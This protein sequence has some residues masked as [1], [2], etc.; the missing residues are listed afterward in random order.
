LKD[1]I[2]HQKKVLFI[3]RA[4]APENSSTVHRPLK[5]TKF[6]P[7]YGWTP[8]VVT[9]KKHE[10]QTDNSLLKDI[11]REAVISEVFSPEPRNVKAI[12]AE[13]VGKGGFCKLVQYFL[14][15]ILKIYSIIY[16][17]IV[18]IDWYDGWIPFGFFKARQ[19]LKKEDI[20]VIFTDMEPP[21]T[22]IIGLLS[23]KISGMPMVIDYHDPWTTSV[24]ARQ[25][26]GLRKRIA[27]YLEHKILNCADTVIAGKSSIVSELA[28]K[29][30]DID[31]R[32]LVTITSGYDSDDYRDLKK[33]ETS[34]FVITY[35]G[36][37]S[38]KL[39]YSPESFLYALASLIKEGKIPKYDVVSQFVGIVSP[40]Y[41]NRFA[42]LVKDLDLAEVVVCTGGV[43]RR[44]CAEFQLNADVL[45]YIIE[46]L[47]GYN[48]S[49]QYS[50]VLPSKLYEYLFTGN[51]ILG[52]VPPGFEA[53]LIER[54]G[55]GII[56]KPNNIESIKNALLA[57]YKKYK[58]GS[59]KMHTNRE[60]IR[61]FDRKVLT[62]ELAHVFDKIMV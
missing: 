39:Y 43:N 24:N 62:G 27:E 4:F 2:N 7:N 12:L 8:Y 61:K 19:I 57:L 38:E 48:V 3:S 18:L 42:R 6:L 26:S 40:G 46:S 5:F 17:R 51:T 20:D 22:S 53:D 11:P 1:H 35:T 44:K 32:K 52:I 59:L 25:S 50:G 47:H 29:F 21:S 14:T 28:D 37:I 41:R 54:T 15:A 58:N 31:E 36:K 16:Y 55:I 23:K 60:E 30:S 9:T 10:G 13:K 34:K 45:L 49:L 33:V 56:A